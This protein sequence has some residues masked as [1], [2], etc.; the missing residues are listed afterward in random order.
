MNTDARRLAAVDAQTYWMSAK[1]P[2]DQF[3]LFVFDGV[4]RVDNALVE[5]LR[6]RAAACPDLC[7]RIIDDQPWRYPSWVTGPVEPSQFVV[8]RDDAGA[9]WDACLAAVARLAETQL[10]RGR[11]RGGCTCSRRCWVPRR[12]GPR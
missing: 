8:H 1:I 3:V 5:D 10:I 11:P 2:N 6:V 4:V 12:V 7:L 9:H